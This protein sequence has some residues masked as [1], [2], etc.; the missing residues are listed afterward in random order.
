MRASSLQKTADAKNAKRIFLAPDVAGK[1]GIDDG[2]DVRVTQGDASVVL[3]AKLDTR[4]AKG[5]VRIAAALHETSALGPMFG[6]VAL[7]KISMAAAAE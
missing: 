7:E 4:L 5:C 6:V 1:H 2:A 3:Q